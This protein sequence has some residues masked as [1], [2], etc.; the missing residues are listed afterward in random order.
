MET[1]NCIAC[2]K[3]HP[4]NTCNCCWVYCS[5]GRE[6]CGNCGSQE[7]YRMNMPED[8]DE[9]QYWCCLQCAK[10]GLSGCAMCI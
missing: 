8:D 6:I 9:A 1:I 7:L 5:C 2:G 4:K 10:C 3:E